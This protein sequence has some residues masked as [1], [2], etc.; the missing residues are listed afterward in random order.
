MEPEMPVTAKDA[1]RNAIQFLAEF[2]PDQPDVR[3]EEVKPLADGWVVTLSF[4]DPD[5]T[6][7]ANAVAGKKR[8]YK[9]VSIDDSGAA[10]EFMIRKI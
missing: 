8:L 1:V 2:F 10:R 9:D 3:L 7:L 5:G 4:P 6:P